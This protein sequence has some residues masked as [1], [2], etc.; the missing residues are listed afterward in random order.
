MSKK[1]KL[2][3]LSGGRKFVVI[4]E[5]VYNDSIYYFTNEIIDD[6]TSDI[7]KIFTIKKNDKSEEILEIIN[8]R[9]IIKAVCELLQKKD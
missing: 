6:N 9:D 2:L 7:F 5:V 1:D 3:T 4:D 8:N